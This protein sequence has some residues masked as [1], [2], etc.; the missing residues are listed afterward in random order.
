MHFIGVLF[1]KQKNYSDRGAQ[2]NTNILLRDY[3]QNQYWKKKT[4]WN[5]INNN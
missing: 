4:A 5:A 1:H 3:V 2:N